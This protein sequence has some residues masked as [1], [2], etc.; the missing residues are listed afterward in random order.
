MR[1]SEADPPIPSRMPRRRRSV[2]AIEK[3]HPHMNQTIVALIACAAVLGGCGTQQE[4]GREGDPTPAPT[5]GSADLAACEQAMREQFE[6]AMLDLEGGSRPPECEGVPDQDLEDIATTIINEAFEGDDETATAE[7]TPVPE[8]GNFSDLNAMTYDDGLGVKVSDLTDFAP[9]ES[10]AFDEAPAY[11]QV[12]VTITNNTGTDFDPSGFYATASSGGVEAPEIFDS[13][14]GIDGSPTT[15]VIPGKSVSFPIAF[16][17]QDPAD[18][19]LE[20]TPSFEH[21]STIFMTG[22]T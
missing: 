21:D 8:Y 7:E 10:A 11:L 17:V 1:A 20:I 15:T 3:E 19:L 6:A 16:S 18:F 14:N 12:T 2:P 13:E 5:L 22:A 9:S 4:A